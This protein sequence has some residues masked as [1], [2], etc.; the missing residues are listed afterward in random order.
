[1]PQASRLSSADLD[2]VMRDAERLQ[3]SDV[4]MPSRSY[5]HISSLDDTNWFTWRFQFDNVL[6]A[7]GLGS[8]QDDSP[9]KVVDQKALAC[10]VLNVKPH[11]QSALRTA[12]TYKEGM[13]LLTDLFEVS[14]KAARLELMQ[15]MADLSMDT[16]GMSHYVASVHDLRDEF[17]AVGAEM[18]EMQLV[19]A[20]LN[21]L[22]DNYGVYKAIITSNDGYLTLAHAIPKLMQAERMLRAST[23]RERIGDRGA[24]FA[25]RHIKKTAVY[26]DDILYH[27]CGRKGHKKYECKNREKDAATARQRYGGDVTGTAAHAAS[28]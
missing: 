11:L 3:A 21:G 22:D 28:M 12:T 17:K 18:S 10:L 27:Y 1:M 14:N 24:A 26:A 5:T 4:T 6:M 7:L 19:L 16:K 23:P 20:M 8:A 13:K 9:S 15:R 25:A 2:E